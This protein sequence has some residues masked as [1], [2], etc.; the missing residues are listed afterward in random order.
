LK[1]G[2]HDPLVDS[3]VELSAIEGGAKEAELE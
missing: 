2:T 1:K 3:G